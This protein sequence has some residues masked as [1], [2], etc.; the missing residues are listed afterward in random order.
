MLTRSS[1]RRIMAVGATMVAAALLALT[2]GVAA[3][4][5]PTV[6]RFYAD[7]G[8]ACGY[9]YTVGHLGWHH[10]HPAVDVRGTVYDNPQDQTWVCRDDGRFTVAHFVAYN[11]NSVAVDR[12]AARVDNGAATFGF[13]LGANTLPTRIH[14]VVIQVCRHTVGS[15]VP[16]YCGARAVYDH[17]LP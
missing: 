12:Q 2:P 7:S 4:D 5:T 3:A 16:D 14:R 10:G 8:D 11:S 1:R 9:G 15:T 6:H 13:T 17:P